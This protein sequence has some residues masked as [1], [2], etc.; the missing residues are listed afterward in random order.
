MLWNTIRRFARED[1]GI[2]MLEW[3][4]V[5][6][7]FATAGAVMWG[8]LGTTVSGELTSIDTNLTGSALP[9]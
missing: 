1:E 8:T 7:L 3:A 4:I 2:E 6:A 5:A 9:F